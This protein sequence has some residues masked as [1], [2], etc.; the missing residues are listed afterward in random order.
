MFAKS[1][2]IL[3]RVSCTSSS[4]Y[5]L[6]IQLL[7]VRERDLNYRSPCKWDLSIPLSYKALSRHRPRLLL[8]SLFQKKNILSS[9]LGFPID[10]HM[11]RGKINYLLSSNI[12]LKGQNFT[13]KKKLRTYSTLKRESVCELHLI[14][15]KCGFSK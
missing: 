15:K 14:P 4:I 11:N 9:S 1:I 5:F 12:F 7:Q 2:L 10:F 13:K 8:L 3:D 6:I